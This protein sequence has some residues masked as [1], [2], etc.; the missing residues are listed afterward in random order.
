MPIVNPAI[1]EGQTLLL[2]DGTRVRTLNGA[3]NPSPLRDAWPANLPWS[4][5]VRVE[6]SDVGVDWFVHA[7]GT[8]STTELK[9]RSDIG[10]EDAV[11]RLARPISTAPDVRASK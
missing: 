3:T 6:R 10:R 7:D 2:P 1:P 8:R 5:I 4:P 11:T 9:W